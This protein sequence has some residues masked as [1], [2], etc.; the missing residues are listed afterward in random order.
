MAYYNYNKKSN[1]NTTSIIETSK[2][3]SL[4][5]NRIIL[6][7][8]IFF[9]IW[10]ISQ[11]LVIQ[12][13]YGPIF[14]WWKEHGGDKY[15]NFINLRYVLSY[16]YSK[17]LYY[18]FS[19]FITPIATLSP[20]AIRIIVGKI[21]KYQRYTGTDGVQKGI[22]TPKSL[23]ETVKLSPDD[24]DA[25]FDDWFKNSDRGI[26][27]VKTNL[28]YQIDT[29]KTQDG[30]TQYTFTALANDDGTYGLYPGRD[31]PTGWKGLIQEWCGPNWYWEESNDGMLYPVCDPSVDNP[32]EI[33][34]MNGT[35]RG[36][37][38]L[39][40]MGIA[41]DSPIVIYFCN[42]FYNDNSMTVDAT[43]MK[44]LLGEDGGG[45]NPGGWL[46][47]ILGVESE[48]KS[49]D[50][51][52]NYI[53]TELK[54]KPPPAPCSSSKTK[55]ITSGFLAGALTALP[56]LGFAIATRGSNGLAIALLGAAAG[57]ISGY[58]AYN[59]DSGC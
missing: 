12:V 10:I 53:W 27:D 32:T 23:C 21:L 56:Q 29:E 9:V 58:N 7:I 22:L 47:Y 38:F 50:D 55:S 49:V 14:Q 57:G 33:W 51:I 11:L 28:R 5:T 6:Y 39:A 52:E 44:N 36:D 17:I 20:T 43:A 34:F 46:G 54:Y 8:F 41:P 31:D 26:I 35:G 48:S 37:N 15:N 3:T 40:R 2:E 25:L 13:N 18:I 4:S 19:M 42:G 30:N 59:S 16:Y 24:G 1:N 45:A